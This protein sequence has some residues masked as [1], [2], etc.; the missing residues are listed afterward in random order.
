MRK[1]MNLDVED[2][3]NTEISLNSDKIKTLSQWNDHIKDE[4][5]SQTVSFVQKPTGVLV[6]K[7]MIDELAV[8][9]GI[10]K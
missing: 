9:I 8:E 1:E 10:R 2:R 4:T 7:W 5:R 3:I 6:K